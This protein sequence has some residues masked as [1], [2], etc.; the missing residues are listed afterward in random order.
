M[1]QYALIISPQVVT[2]GNQW[3]PSVRCDIISKTRIKLNS[4]ST[5]RKKKVR[6]Q[7]CVFCF[8]LHHFGYSDF[9]AAN[10]SIKKEITRMLMALKW[11]QTSGLEFKDF[12]K[13]L[14][15]WYNKKNAK[16]T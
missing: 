8:T 16:Y 12:F 14:N 6:P 2:A 1:C 4:V 9:D 15:F 3:Y 11:L 5:L 13:K 7:P 10:L